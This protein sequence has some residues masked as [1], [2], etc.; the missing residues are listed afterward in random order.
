MLPALLSAAIPSMITGGASLLG[1]IFGANQSS[2]NT[3]M[4]FQQQQHL[5]QQSMDFNANQAQINRDWSAGQADVSRDWNAQQ[6]QVN[7]DYQTQMSNTAFQRSRADAMAA[8]LNPMVLAGMGGASTPVGGVAGGAQATSGA[9]SHGGSAAPTPQNKHPFQDLGE[10]VGRAV[11]TAV[12]MKTLEKMTDEIANLQAQRGRITAETDY[13]KQREK[14][15]QWETGIR[16]KEDAIRGLQM[17]GHRF[18]AKQAEDLLSMPD[19]LRSTV[20][21]GGFVG[22]KASKAFG[23]ITDIISSARRVKDLLPQRSTREVTRDHHRGGSSTFEER[24]NY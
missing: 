14:T 17:P 18:S 11:N 21:Q 19:W 9:A 7:R 1:S 10:N 4:Q 5:N 8:G 24:W 12:T 23:P 2:A 22:D 13:V 16:S 6:A 3:Q 20:V 15:E